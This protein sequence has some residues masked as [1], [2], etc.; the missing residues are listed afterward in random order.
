MDNGTFEN[1]VMNGQ[2]LLIRKK[3]IGAKRT[4]VT[5]IPAKTWE[6][7]ERGAEYAEPMDYSEVKKYVKQNFSNILPKDKIY[8]VSVLTSYG[9]KSGKCFNRNFILD[10]DF[11]DPMEK[12]DEAHYFTE[13]YG[14]GITY[15]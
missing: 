6:N 10:G 1:A 11:F 9:W 3:D 7:R 14:I 4:T 8:H 2:E 5:I 13:I 12:Y 15:H